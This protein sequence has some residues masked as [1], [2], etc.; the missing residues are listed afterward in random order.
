M[1][2]KFLHRSTLLGVFVPIFVGAFLVLF[3]VSCGGSTGGGPENDPSSSSSNLGGKP[4]DPPIQVDFVEVTRF[5]LNLMAGDS[6]LGINIQVDINQNSHGVTEFDLV[7]VYLGTGI[8]N[9]GKGSANQFTYTATGSNAIPLEHCG[10]ITV[11]VCPTVAGERG[12]ESKEVERPLIHCMP[13]SSSAE[14]SSS[15]IAVSRP[16]VPVSFSGGSSTVA[17]NA[18]T[19]LVLSTASTTNLIANADIYY[20]PTSNGVGTLRAGKADVF[21]AKDFFIG[22]DCDVI[23]NTASGIPTPSNTSQFIPCGNWGGDNLREFGIA[24]TSR[25]FYYLIKTNGAT[26]WGESWF[27]VH[28]GGTAA[29]EGIA[30]A[31]KVGN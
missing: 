1:L 10:K 19:G 20:V 11:S 6:H 9:S 28:L 17:I 21:I 30:Q 4:D 25:N 8:I 3:A 18:S 15:S 29:M 26:E 31:W 23:R 27:L 14:P 12:C 16:L 7:E 13:S 5:D 2:K 24:A 22:S